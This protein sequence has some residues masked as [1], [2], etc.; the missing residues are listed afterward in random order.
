MSIHPVNNAVYRLLLEVVKPLKLPIIDASRMAS[1]PARQRYNRPRIVKSILEHDCYVAYH[2]NNMAIG[3]FEY[4]HTLT[5]VNFHK[6]WLVCP[7]DSYSC[8]KVANVPIQLAE[9]DFI[10]IAQKLLREHIKFAKDAYK[11][12][13]D[14][15]WKNRQRWSEQAQA[16]MDRP[17]PA[18]IVRVHGKKK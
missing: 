3:K 17:T 5:Y 7:L 4:N 9:P 12:A 10:K 13:Y 6:E 18:P 16:A 8:T 1:L 14:I 2:V 15:E 11:I